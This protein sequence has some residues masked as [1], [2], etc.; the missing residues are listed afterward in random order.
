MK[1]ET[2]EAQRWVQEEE[3]LDPSASLDE[4]TMPTQS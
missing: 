3:A 1:R 2:C 4:R